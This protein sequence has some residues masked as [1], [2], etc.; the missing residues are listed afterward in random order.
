MPDSVKIRITG[1]ASQFNKEVSGLGARVKNAAAGAGSV[2][3]GMLASQVITRGVSM[4]TNGIRSAINTG[5]EFEAAMSQVA[6]ISGATAEELEKL[7]ETA[8][9]YGETTKF[10]A[11]QAAEALNYMALAGW[12]A[13]QSMDALPGV[14]SLAAAS[15]MEL[16]AASDAVTDFIS[17]FGMEA[18]DAAY[19]SDL[20]A[21]AQSNANTSASQLADAYGNCASSMHAAGQD[22]ETTTAMLMALSNQGIKGSEAGTQMA[23]MMR[24]LTQKMSGG[25]IMIGQTAVQVAD[26]AGNFRDLN[27]IMADVGAAV[28][29]MGTAE[30]SAAIMETFTARSIKAI[31]T[32]LNEGMENV[33]AYEDALRDS[34]G[35][36]GEQAEIM[37]DNLQGDIQ[38]FQSALEG[39]QITASES[40]SGVARSIV[41]E[42]TSIMEALTRGGK[43]GGLSGIVDAAIDMIPSLLDKLTDGFEGLINGIAAKMPTVVKR[44]ID[45]LPNM[46]Q[47]GLKLTPVIVKSVTSAA[48]A[49]VESL[50][51]NLPQYVMMI[52]EGLPGLLK[53][54]L[55]G[56]LHIVDGL[57]K[58]I[59]TA[60]GKLGLRKLR[61]GEIL[62]N[63]IDA[64][65]PELTKE[66]KIAAS[67]EYSV[68]DV[69]VVTAEEAQQM[70]DDALETFRTT[71][72]NAGIDAG[73]ADAITT[74]VRSGSGYDAFV[75]ALG[76]WGQSEEQARTTADNVNEAFTIFQTTFSGLKLSEDAKKAIT[77]ALASGA[78]AK[79]IGQMLVGY[80]V[81]PAEANTAANQLTLAYGM[82]RDS[83]GDLDF[84]SIHTS[85]EN[86]LANGADVETVKT[87]L[88]GYG[89]D[90]TAAAQAAETLVNAN[91]KKNDTMSELGLDDKAEQ[92]LA[93]ALKNGASVDQI[94]N[95]L[96]SYGVDQEKAD[97]AAES[98]TE[99]NADMNGAMSG[100]SLD[101]DGKVT[102]F[103]VKAM[104]DRGMVDG[105]LAL[106]N[107]SGVDTDSITASY[108]TIK[109]SVGQG[110][111]KV[112]QALHDSLVNG[113][114]DDYDAD[115]AQAKLD[116]KNWCTQA[117]SV[118]DE[119]EN[120]QI[121][122]AS[123]EYEGATLE[124]K[125]AEIKTA[126][127]DMRTTIDG[128]VT[129]T[130]TW[131]VNATN[132]LPEYVESQMHILQ[133]L[134]NQVYALDA[135]MRTLDAS[136]MTVGAADRRAVESGALTDSASQMSAISYTS[137]E[138]DNALQQS[139]NLTKQALAK[140][141]EEY[142]SDTDAYAAA[143]EQALAE[144]QAREDAAYANYNAHMSK[145]AQQTIQ[146][147]DGA[148]D[149]LEKYGVNS[150]L[151]DAATWFDD[152]IAGKADPGDV[153]DV[154]LFT[155]DIEAFA[156]EYSE[157]LGI[158]KDNI[159]SA[160]QA[161]IEGGRQTN[162]SEVL[163]SAYALE[164][165]VSV[166][167][168]A[169]TIAAG[170]PDIDTLYDSAMTDAFGELDMT[171]ILAIWMT[172]AEEGLLK[173][174][175]EHEYDFSNTE[176]VFDYLVRELLPKEISPDEAPVVDVTPKLQVHE[177]ADNA[178]LLTYLKNTLEQGFATDEF[179]NG[180][181]SG[182]NAMSQH[183]ATAFGVEWADMFSGQSATDAVSAMVAALETSISGMGDEVSGETET[184][185]DN[186]AAGL[187][188]GMESGKDD[189]AAAAADTAGAIPDAAKEVLDEH[190]PS[191]VMAGIGQNAA[192]GLA[193]GLDAQAGTVIAAAKRLA[194]IVRDTIKA[195]L[196]INS[197]SK[198]MAELGAYTGEGFGQ[199]LDASLDAAMRSARSI[200]GEANFAPRMDFSGVGDMLG[201]SVQDIA[202]IES[203]RPI[204]LLLDGKVLGQ[205]TRRYNAAAANRYNRSLA[206]G[207]DKA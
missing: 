50:A 67:V 175:S 31:N 177:S 37:L 92:A 133:D 69:T 2:L 163:M 195:A 101:D 18:A 185:G 190:S 48:S 83:F 182:N 122:A 152:Y 9:Y 38:I 13:T 43:A 124:T 71:L 132:K 173:S 80:G 25:K 26:A 73:T 22:I 158:S 99:A 74:A 137:Q 171:Q 36:A 157:A 151:L 87:L 170:F 52:F 176:D 6:A 126:A 183:I 62:Q 17:A 3:K 96:V 125:I 84:H 144:A 72:T 41:Q 24:D 159:I 63:Q 164:H 91:K 194:N 40:F 29:G 66:L 136:V 82:M 10:T 57:F 97:A 75:E 160:Q 28:E 23:A 56:A 104:L 8:R 89:V 150:W 39:L 201:G 203:D 117:K 20:M 68:D 199:G 16:G 138:L 44:L 118:V 206:L 85:I 174:A 169:A 47:S 107:L 51:E 149:A 33:N 81:N 128:V 77:D 76:V 90:E 5:M 134:I 143:K 135:Q 110:F 123:Q 59:D 105:A 103:L 106:L 116:I 186:V 7:T 115:F 167:N 192:L 54:V 30:R 109:T 120:N 112:V 127:D 179:W 11:S 198:V 70:V 119:W 12:D 46:L 161:F 153:T 45:Q 162:F 156:D 32:I 146:S 142:G 60:L 168:L 98:L 166:D 154:T 53:S 21:Y 42:G 130:E 147:V 1:D 145:I 94:R 19:M 102:A 141:A 196:K 79:E 131:T 140:A 35:T 34:S 55:E 121:V 172:A 189:V 65:D 139:E 204:N 86:A 64:I 148:S 165:G 27:D 4:L 129:D 95:M 108:E 15:G 191:Q 88:T 58:G 184:A 114:P 202:Q 14:L 49:A 178:G 187:V 93:Y 188:T 113:I 205:A 200:V 155:S 180:L 197:P 111:A 207:V 181:V 78:D 61:F 100:L 193:L